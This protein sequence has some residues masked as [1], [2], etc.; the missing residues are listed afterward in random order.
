MI[1]DFQHKDGFSVDDT[2]RKVIFK[3]KSCPTGVPKIPKKS[4]K[5]PK[6]PT[7]FAWCPCCGAGFSSD[8]DRWGT[9]ICLHCG[10]K[11]DWS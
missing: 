5:I 3:E 7:F 11:L 2:V 1:R 4:Q 6:N 8:S 10:Q 9:E